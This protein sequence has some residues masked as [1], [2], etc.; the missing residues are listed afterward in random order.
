MRPTGKEATK[1]NKRYTA[2]VLAYLDEQMETLRDQMPAAIDKE[3]EKAV[4]RSRVATRRL[5]S[6]LGMLEP[7]LPDAKAKKLLVTGKKLRRR[8]GPV[9]DL[10]VMI[11]HLGDLP[12]AQR[13]RFA[14]SITF[15]REKLEAQRPKVRKGL[16][17]GPDPDAL[18]ETFGGWW[19]VRQQVLGLADAVWATL[20]SNVH[21]QLHEFAR[22]ADECAGVTEPNPDGPKLDVH[23]LRI[24]G[25]A[26][27]YTLEIADSA[28]VHLPKTVARQFK[29]MQDDLGLWHDFVILADRAVR[30]AIDAELVLH[31]SE[32]ARNILDMGKALLT[33]SE[34]HLEK[35]R[36]HWRDNGKTLVETVHAA[37]PVTAEAEGPAEAAQ[38]DT[39][40]TVEQ[41]PAPELEFIRSDRPTAADETT[42]PASS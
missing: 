22:Q 38:P 31:E 8:L 9:R 16:H 15:L 32:L 30:E 35:F 21:D 39:E 40:T 5:K 25:K 14:P 29:A 18:L 6:G 24:A 20:S 13:R 34:R 23:E 41:D 33:L 1:V 3:N 37:F 2:G 36:K 4:H 19:V 26:L 12:A 10:D 17:K 7:L 28:G 42:V 27:R 11:G